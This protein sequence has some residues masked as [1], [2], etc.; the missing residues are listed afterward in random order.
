MSAI[1]SLPIRR[2]PERRRLV[3]LAAAVLFVGVFLLAEQTDKVALLYA[4]PLTLLSLELGL[5]GGLGAAAVSTGAL[6]FSTSA[7]GV[8]A[9]GVALVCIGAVAGRFGDRMRDA[10]R[11]QQRLL[12]SGLALAHLEA[13]DELPALVARRA[14]DLA[15]AQGARVELLGGEVGEAGTTQSSD[16]VRIA[17]ELRNK[18]YGGL[19]VYRSRPLSREDRAT[20]QI[21][22]LQTAVAIESR[23]L[24][25]RKA[26]LHELI[27]RQEAERH[28]V[29]HELHDEAAQM[30]AAVLL[31]LGALERELGAS[32]SGPRLRELRSDI[33]STLRSLRS[34]AA[35]LRPQAL[36]LGLRV[37]LEQLAADAREHDFADVRI[38]L[39]GVE[40][41]TP[42][43]ETM[44][45]RVVQEALDAVGSAQSASIEGRAGDGEIAIEIR[46]ARSPIDPARLAVLK[47]RMD[48]AA[49]TLT[50]EAAG[51]RAVIPLLSDS[52]GPRP[53]VT[54][55]LPA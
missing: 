8:V 20:L 42:E 36:R 15:H 47:A 37:A 38:A 11:R 6:A 45:Y 7:I 12:S 41:L 53:T 51:L 23:Q 54:A 35:G 50:S 10:Q 44:V 49:G 22:V 5:A 33:D 46:G 39:D 32:P 25:E 21:L 40:G 4:V 19:W 2:W 3:L 48:L 27:A 1:A 26:Q 52:S 9:G 18:P 28:Y 13:A 55:A 17:I 14:L 31:S 29:A 30:L 43:A 24:L 16:G 34:L